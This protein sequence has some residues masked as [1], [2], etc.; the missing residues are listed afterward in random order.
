M[1]KIF[2]KP[3]TFNSLYAAE[4]WLRQNGY[5]YGSLAGD[6]PV[7]LFKGKCYVSKWYNLSES[8]KKNVNGLMTSKNFREGPVKIEIFFIETPDPLSPNPDVRLLP[9]S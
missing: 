4:S 9:Q 5:S 6:S 2:D 8:E 1:I 7:A 3:G